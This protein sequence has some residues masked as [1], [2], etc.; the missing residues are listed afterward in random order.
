MSRRC[1][2]HTIAVLAA[3][4]VMWFGETGA[5]TCGPG[6]ERAIFTHTV[7][8]DLPLSTFAN[9]DL[10]V[11]QPTYARSYLMTAY[12]HLIGRPL[13]RDEQLAMR[14]IWEQ[15]LLQPEVNVWDSTPRDKRSFNDPNERAQDAWFARRRL[16][17]GMASLDRIPLFQ[18]TSPKS[19]SYFQNCLPS[20][21]ERAGATLDRLVQASGVSSP[22]VAEWARAQDIVFSNCERAGAVPAVLAS[23]AAPAAAADRDYQ[24]AAA[25]FYAR[26]FDG[27][28]TRFKQIARDPGS[29]WRTL[30]PYLAAR[31]LIRKAALA[32]D[33]GYDLPL[34]MKAH[35]EL[36]AIL[37][38]PAQA[39]MHHATRELVGFVEFRVDPAARIREIGSSIARG[40]TSDSFRNDA[41]DFTRLI[42]R[43]YGD[44]PLASS[45]APDSVPA[46]A[47]AMADWIVT[48]Q[49]PGPAAAAHA[50]TRWQA[51]REDVWLVA[52]LSKIDASGANVPALLTAAAAIRPGSPA[53]PTV[54]YH[55][56][57]L[58]IARGD[59]DR[60]RNDLDT[61]LATS[62][63]MPKSA[64]N[65]FRAQR[66]QVS[67]NLQDWLTFA[68][69]QPAT[70]TYSQPYAE[71]PDDPA[72]LRLPKLADP[73]LF[74]IDST[75]IL[76][77][78]FAIARLSEIA[79]NA[80]LPVARRRDV[81]ITAWTR[82]VLLKHTATAAD[83]A[84]TLRTLVPEMAADLDA[85][86]KS[87]DQTTRELA[88]IT[89]LLRFPG[90]RLNVDDGLGRDEAIG[91]IE[92]F[93]DNWWCV[94]NA[95]AKST[96]PAFVLDADRA[97][98]ASEYAQLVAIGTAPD[99]LA[100]EAVR[101]ARLLPKDPRSPEVLHLAV[102][103]TRYGCTSKATGAQSKAAFTLLHQ[104]YPQSEWAKKTP[105][106]Y[107]G[108]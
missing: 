29:P 11:L 7:H 52:A 46:I 87:P 4:A 108:D 67:A 104:R 16:V 30:G 55:S 73:R 1:L 17:P 64:V 97:S 10:G 28:A 31:A 9:G 32:K 79:R 36:R 107:K 63:R 65:L 23:N 84:P 20:A 100:S 95:T 49:W 106:W 105:F 57:R 74:D 56:I 19:F 21:F 96:P 75:Q 43:L 102:R 101:L 69:R 37:A 93:R 26:D 88:G 80:V 71:I 99:Y 14:D 35:E 103:S 44:A 34:L 13:S 98:A 76:N 70:S 59:R 5:E 3:V 27:A 91:K 86:L 33:E 12:R 72:Y 39:G 38:D 53:Y 83:L 45:P 54:A 40:G 8:P 24:I 78:R 2:R 48:F 47:D 41:D 42:D 62:Q 60:A 25:L 90:V 89:T 18:E 68:L 66:M 58:A 61:I 81:A 22:Q 82:A 15:R 6:F 77:E 94:Q 92:N 50:I 85:Y 51:T